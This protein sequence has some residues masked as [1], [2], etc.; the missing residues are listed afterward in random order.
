VAVLPWPR[1][2]LRSIC[3]PPGDLKIHRDWRRG[4]WA[5]VAPAGSPAQQ[6][7]HVRPDPV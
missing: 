5:R 2:R 4:L 7:P 6:G 1:E 3:T